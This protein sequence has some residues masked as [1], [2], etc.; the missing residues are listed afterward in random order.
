MKRCK[1]HRCLLGR[2]TH[3]MVC[4]CTWRYNAGNGGI[5]MIEQ[6]HDRVA[7]LFNEEITLHWYVGQR[8]NMDILAGNRAGNGKQVIQFIGATYD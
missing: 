3:R 6:S 2:K 7:T 4:S 8:I 1:P 5:Y